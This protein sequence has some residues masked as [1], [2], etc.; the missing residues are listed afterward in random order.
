MAEVYWIHTKK[1]TD[2]FTMGYI[3]FTSRDSAT[4]FEEHLQESK[5]GRK[6]DIIHKAIRKYGSEIIVTTLVKC[7]EEYGL[8]LENKL[9]PTVKIGWNSVPGGGKPPSWKGRKKTPEQV[10]AQSARMKASGQRPPIHLPEVKAKSRATKKQTGTWNLVKDTKLWV[11]WEKADILYKAWAQDNKL[12]R[13][14]LCSIAQVP[15]TDRMHDITRYFRSGFVPLE[16]KEWIRDFKQNDIKVPEITPEFKLLNT[17]HY[18]H[19]KALSLWKE[20]SSVRDFILS[21]PDMSAFAVNKF[22]GLPDKSIYILHAKIKAG[23]NPAEDSTYLSWLLEYNLKK[24]AEN[25]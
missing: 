22:Y 3:G 17:P 16:S 12:D 23:W 1:H 5:Q 10:A 25:V 7:D 9:R 18:K 6:N 2:L 8:W 15:Y 24:E 14:L 20:S 19:P 11:Y 13:P 4:R 21:N